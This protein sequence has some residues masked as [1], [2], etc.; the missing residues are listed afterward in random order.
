MGTH[1]AFPELMNKKIEMMRKTW[2]D[3]EEKEK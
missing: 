2:K 1:N 3:R